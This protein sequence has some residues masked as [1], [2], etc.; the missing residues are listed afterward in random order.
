MDHSWLAGRSTMG[1]LDFS[2]V[3]Y[4]WGTRVIFWSVW[5]FQVNVSRRDALAAST[6]M[7]NS[8]FMSFLNLEN[9][10]K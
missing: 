5:N 8:N 2:G 10:W 7:F 6:P 1:T 9:N 4:V 3:K